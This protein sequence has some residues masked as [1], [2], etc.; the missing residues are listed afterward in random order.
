MASKME[1]FIKAG[2]GGHP[3]LCQEALAEEL[4]KLFQGRKY[5][6]PAGLRGITVYQQEVPI[7]LE[8]DS[9]ADTENALTPFLIVRQEAGRVQ[10]DDSPQRVE[11]SVILCAYGEDRER[12]GWQDVVNMR[13]PIIQYLCSHPYFGGAFTVLRPITWEMQ[14]DDTHPYYYGVINL[15]CTSPALSQDEALAGLI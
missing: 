2:I 1:A 7:S 9:D 15:T 5:N 14:Q 10:D 13:E 3:R 12:Q 11:M 8:N 6:S 4:K